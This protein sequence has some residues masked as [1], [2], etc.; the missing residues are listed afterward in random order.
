[1]FEDAMKLIS[2]YLAFVAL[3]GHVGYAIGGLLRSTQ[4]KPS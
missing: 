2:E 4:Y 3:E 1:M